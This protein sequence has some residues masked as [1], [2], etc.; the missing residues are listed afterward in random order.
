MRVIIDHQF[1]AKSSLLRCSL[2]LTEHYK[3]E[4]GKL[5]KMCMLNGFNKT[6]KLRKRVNSEI[7]VVIDLSGIYMQNWFYERFAKLILT[8]IKYCEGKAVY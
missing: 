5:P 1:N 6:V 8:K 2:V 3:I 4:C 7:L